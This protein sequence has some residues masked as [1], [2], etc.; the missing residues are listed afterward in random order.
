MTGVTPWRVMTAAACVGVVVLAAC[1][2]EPLQGVG[3]RSADWIS[4]AAADEPAS[5]PST[6]AAPAPYQP[7]ETVAWYN[8]GLGDPTEI[9]EPEEVIA[10]VWSRSSGEDRFV[11]ASPVEIARAL[12]GIKFPDLVPG[13]VNHVTSQLVFS[14][15][16][17]RLSDETVAAFGL[18]SS[19]PYTRSR[20]VAQRAVLWVER[21]EPDTLGEEVAA[22]HS[23][24]GDGCGRFREEGAHGCRAVELGEHP[25]WWV[26]GDEG[27]LLVWYEDPFRYEISCRPDV[28][29]D[30][31][32]MMAQHMRP[33]AELEALEALPL[34]EDPTEADPAAGP[35]GTAPTP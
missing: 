15:G 22:T 27:T 3:G 24:D 26:D 4:S 14:P 34:I 18:W 8:D 28:G 17:G 35:A 11:Q 30:V 21:P 16:S 19:K 10:A 13:D 20:S 1:G 33:L 31:M 9:A 6:R 5:T 7:T 23:N 32:E 2:D 25:G 29:E 12:P